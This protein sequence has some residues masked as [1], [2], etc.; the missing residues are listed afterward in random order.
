MKND[1]AHSGFRWYHP[2][3]VEGIERRDR[4]AA[5][6]FPPALL[7]HE[8]FLSA[9]SLCFRVS[10]LWT[11]PLYTVNKKKTLLPLTL[12]HSYFILAIRKVTKHWVIPRRLC[13]VIPWRLC[14][15]INNILGLLRQVWVFEV[16]LLRTYVWNCG[17]VSI[18]C[19]LWSSFHFK[20]AKGSKGC[21][22]IL[23]LSFWFLYYCSDI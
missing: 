23:L 2:E 22:Y 21:V 11:E 14:T 17:F 13:A 7:Y 10:Q 16:W 20:T 6:W 8:L 15:G 18:S 1:K 9:I 19:S 4:L 12:S 3:W 5:S